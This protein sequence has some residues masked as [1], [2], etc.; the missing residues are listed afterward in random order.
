MLTGLIRM[1]LFSTRHVQER[2]SD[3]ANERERESSDSL[4]RNAPVRSFTAHF[5][6]HVGVAERGREGVGTGRGREDVAAGRRRR[7]V[8]RR[9][10]G[11]GR[12]GRTARQ[13]VR[14]APRCN[15]HKHT[16]MTGESDLAN[17]SARVC[18]LRDVTP[19]L[20]AEFDIRRRSQRSL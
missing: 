11:C 13:V 1:H 17:E 4:M 6:R 20:V 18:N 7:G 15:K 5:G 2:M 8:G 14:R 9:G 10:G 16:F 3:R 19:E 12:R